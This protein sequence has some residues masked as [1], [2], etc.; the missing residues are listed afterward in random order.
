MT[1][2]SIKKG[3]IKVTKRAEQTIRKKKKTTRKRSVVAVEKVNP[4]L[5]FTTDALQTKTIISAGKMA[6]SNAIREAKA[7]GLSITYLHRGVLY[8]E[9]ADGTKVKVG[10]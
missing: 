1:K 2:K 6:G 9:K 7:L 3:A 5:R 4:I 10:K 8:R